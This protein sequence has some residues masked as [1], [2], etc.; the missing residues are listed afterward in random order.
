MS[1]QLH[2]LEAE[3]N[4]LRKRWQSSVNS[5]ISLSEQH[6]ALTNEQSASEKRLQMLQK[7]C[8]QLQEDRSAFLKQLKENNIEPI[9]P[10]L[11]NGENNDNEEPEIEDTRAAKLKVELDKMKS[12]VS[13]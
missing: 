9:V 4:D 6:L 13:H 7:L 5:L 11:K 3:R 1:K 12:A 8:R 10:S 2:I